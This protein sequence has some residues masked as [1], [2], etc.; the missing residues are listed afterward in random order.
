MANRIP[1]Y[2]PNVYARLGTLPVI[3]PTISNL[4]KVGQ[5]L[6]YGNL[7]S[8]QIWVY[9]LWHALP[10]ALYTFTK[11][12]FYAWEFHARFD[13]NHG[14]LKGIAKLLKEATPASP[15]REGWAWAMFEVPAEF[16]LKAEWYLMIADRTAEFMLNW[17][18]LAYLYSGQPIPDSG[19]LYG[20]LVP[21]KL[22]LLGDS[23][24]SLVLFWEWI[25][26]K[27]ETFRSPT[28]NIP[29]EK[30]G[31][32][33]FTLAATPEEYLTTPPANNYSAELWD[34]TDGGG[35]GPQPVQHSNPTPSGFGDHQFLDGTLTQAHIYG[36][37]LRGFGGLSLTS[38]TFSGL[39]YNT[40]K[41][42]LLFDP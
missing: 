24:P 25:N 38:G 11:P 21:Y 23:L 19:F 30:S 26:E 17:T 10:R 31:A 33:M 32:I 15:P 20:T 2:G 40:G 29:A 37:I 12:F 34:F 27:G 41:K 18:S 16:A 14:P 22:V 13:R 42:G 3:G 39:F 36:V 28:L 9:A 1:G 4:G 7:P 6:A 35:F 8:P 5:I